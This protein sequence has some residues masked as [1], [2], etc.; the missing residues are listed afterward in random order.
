M[1]LAK[2]IIDQ[3]NSSSSIELLDYQSAYP[4]GYEDMERRVPDNSLLKRLTGWKSENS[5]HNIIE[6]I[7]GYLR[8][9]SIL[10]D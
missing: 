8:E 10:P 6:D 4:T 9:T 1:N 7:S 2:T 5:I 3:T